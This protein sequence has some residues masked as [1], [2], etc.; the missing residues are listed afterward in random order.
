MAR[1]TATKSATLLPR[2]SRALGL[3]LILVGVS[4]AG[5]SF[6][7]AQVSGGTITGTV[8]DVSGAVID[9]AQVEVVSD[10]THATTHLHTSDAGLFTVPN[11][12]P[13]NYTLIVTA[14]GFTRTK[15]HVI[16]EI[17]KGTVIKIPLAIEGASSE[18]TVSAT[19]S[20]VVDEDS[21]T[22]NQVVDGKT[23]RELPLN[24]R[25][26]TMLS[27]LEPNVH[28][29]DNQ[30]SISAGDNSRA[31][32]GVGT[33]ITIAGTRPQQNVYRLDGIITNDYSGNG[34]GGAL[35][36]TLGV[37]AI[38]EFSVVTSNATSDFGR[39]SGGTISAV[40]RAGTDQFHGSA[41]EFIRNSVFDATPYFST[42]VAP[43]KRN[44]FGGTI[45]GPILKD[46]LFFFFNYEG[47]RQSRTTSQQTT[48]PSPNA[49]QGYL[50][51]TQNAAASNAGCLSSIGGSKAAANSTGVQLVS[52]IDP[53][54]LTYLQFFP[55]PNSGLSGDTGT[56]TFNSNAVAKEDL[57]TGRADYNFSQK[58]TIHFTALNDSSDDTQPDAYDFIYTGLQPYRK[59]FSLAEQHTFNSNLVNFARA[60]YSY[61][62][63]VSPSSSAAINP[64]ATNNSYGFVPGYPIGNL[65]IGGLTSFYGGVNVEGLYSYHYNSYQAGDDL[66]ITHGRHSM[67]AGF[68]FEDI[69]SNDRG[70]TTAGYYTFSSYTSFL[71]NKPQSFASTIPGINVPIYM[72]QKVYGAYFQDAWH[73]A[74]N[75]T[76][77]L[78][79]RYEPTSDLTEAHGH[80]AVLP[81]AQ[82]AAPLTGQPLF[83]NPTYRNFAPRVGVAW[84]P[85]S[86]GKTVARAAYGIYDT[87]PLSYM[88]I[89][90]T[91]NVAPFNQTI[92]VTHPAAG[93][94]PQATYTA[95]VNDPTTPNKYAYVQQNF[96]RPYVEQ[97]ILNIQQQVAPNM[98]I[99]VGY[100]GAHGVRQPTKSNDGNIVEPINPTQ[101][102]NLTW[103]TATLTTTTTNGVTSA[104]KL[105]FGPAHKFNPNTNIGQ[106]D[107]TY[108]NQSTTYNALNASLR[109]STANTRFGI[110]YTW[111]KSL[112][113][114]SSSNG[115]SN[116]TNTS[117]IAPFPREIGAFKG[118]SD[119]NVGS[120]L[121]INVLYIIP[122]P[123]RD[124]FLSYAAKGWQIGGIGR[125]ATGL[126]FTALISG[127]A[128]GLQSASVF[129]FPDR[130]Y[131]GAECHGNPVNLQDKFN[132]LRRECFSYPQGITQSV[133]TTTS[134]STTTTVRTFNPQFG[135]ERRNSIIGPGIQDIDLSLVK[136]TDLNRLREGFHAEFRAE[137][138]NVLNHPMFEVPSRASSAV[139][140][141]AGAA[142][143][144]QILTATSVP[145]RQIQFGLKLIF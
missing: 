87:L 32:R 125:S 117:T 18:V 5:T 140:T 4:L 142:T 11:I 115:G 25:D 24:G 41:Y 74:H 143:S 119:F 70:T 90:S 21:S 34:P 22:L 33:Q 108:F 6:L 124:G 17:S 112:D 113:E 133:T 64:L 20:P 123:K 95:A 127:D 76:L 85:F 14:T 26:W 48:V 134:G 53:N 100:T 120:N 132:Y 55:V 68:S 131:N 10:A 73:V 45:G 138:F 129:D 29:T 39:S 46:H 36:G 30:L 126:P 97:Y 28:T 78:G 86:N 141:A 110:T 80:F 101:I 96:A 19:V 92:S 56:F 81:T 60:G 15:V 54:V 1:P 61:T 77:N 23:T 51:C 42:T 88:F 13:G 71:Q 66:Y 69:Q 135:N 106:T 144:P 121:S 83:H 67:Q 65:Q 43:F 63:V 8:T 2:L 130:N 47:L 31:N 103:P 38:Q 49:R 35:G 128:L 91:L 102:H 62:F 104:P 75:V 12:E 93:S 89:L 114:T 9:R 139:F 116:F 7:R 50:V 59:L 44:Q 105:A 27:T 98:A 84:D 82:S 16:V 57:F 37:D 145:E 136:T 107:S 109:R 94:F 99:E 72:R 79:I 111:S 52:G 122:G 58:D 40:T 118:L 3:V 137:F